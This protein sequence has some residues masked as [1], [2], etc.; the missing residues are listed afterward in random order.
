MILASIFLIYVGTYLYKVFCSYLNITFKLTEN[1]EKL[2]K[3]EK[4]LHLGHELYVV[5]ILQHHSLVENAI[6][7]LLYFTLREIVVSR[8][9]N[10][11]P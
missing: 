11:Y 5:S 3:K 7:R 2:E 9:M 10:K 6:S 1:V 8:I 4:H